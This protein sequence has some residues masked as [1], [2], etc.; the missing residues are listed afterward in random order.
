MKYLFLLTF[1]IAFISCSKKENTPPKILLSGTSYKAAWITGNSP[2]NFASNIRFISE[3]TLIYRLITLSDADTI[4]DETI[5][6]N[7]TF[8]QSSKVMSYGNLPQ[9]YK[10]M[11]D[12]LVKFIVSDRP[13]NKGDT[14]V[15]LVFYKEK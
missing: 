9:Y 11:G 3:D 1:L 8:D 6:V 2:L 5:Y 13:I 4:R 10:Y 12:S 7:Y 15:D 14:I